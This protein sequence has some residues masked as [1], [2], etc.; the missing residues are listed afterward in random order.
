MAALSD[1]EVH[2]LAQRIDSLPA[3]GAL[4]NQDLILIVLIAILAYVAFSPSLPFSSPYEVKA[5]FSNAANI[6][7]RSPVRI[8]GVN[9]GKVVGVDA[10][11][12]AQAAVLT[13]EI[14]DDGL[15]IHADATAKIRPRIFLEGNF[16][17]DLS[18]GTPT[19]PE[20]G[21]GDDAADVHARDAHR[22]PRADRDRA[23]ELRLDLEAAR[24]R[25]RLREP[26]VKQRE[27]DHERDQPDRLR[28]DRALSLIHI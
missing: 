14:E 12:D 3:G 18:P 9:V 24:E 7:A 13:L 19:A 15:P 10:A 20:L 11:P 6:Q 17:V 2:A 22:R 26:E 28:A 5:V 25:D 16:F 23:L 4:S 1:A 21:D 27:Q 8:A